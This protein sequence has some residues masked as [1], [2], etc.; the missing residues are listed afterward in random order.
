MKGPPLIR[1]NTAAI[2]PKRI[3]PLR[4]ARQLRLSFSRTL[5]SGIAQL[6]ARIVRR[7]ECDQ[8]SHWHK[9]ALKTYQVTS[10][11]CRSVEGF[12]FVR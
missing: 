10:I 4:N 5:V 3:L 1:E 6:A 11:N 12:R 7:Q 2:S 9:T 8:Q